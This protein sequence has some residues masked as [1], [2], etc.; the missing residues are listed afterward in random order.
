[1]H[2]YDIIQAPHFFRGYFYVEKT[3][4]KKVKQE[5]APVSGL[6]FAG[7]ELSRRGKVK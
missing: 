7:V 4:L 1:V 2:L 5:Y 3:S 6:C